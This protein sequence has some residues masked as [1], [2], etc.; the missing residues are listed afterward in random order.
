MY[1]VVVPSSF[2][3]W[4]TSTLKKCITV[5]PDV[6]GSPQK[7]EKKINK[8]LNNREQRDPGIISRESALLSCRPKLCDVC[9][10]ACEGSFPFPIPSIDV[11]TAL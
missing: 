3:S 8:K 9:V 7:P 5:V 4:S 1:A 2:I 11:A 6:D 10:Y